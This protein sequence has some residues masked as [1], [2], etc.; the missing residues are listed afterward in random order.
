VARTVRDT[1]LQTRAARLRLKVRGKP[2]WRALERGLHLGYRRTRTGGGSWSARRFVGQGYSEKR[3]G[4]ADDLQDADGAAVLSFGDAQEK[5][6]RWW[7]SEK[8]EELGLAPVTGPYTVVDALRDYF[9]ERD[10]RGSKGVKADR[11]ASEARIVP[12]LG[13]IELARL[14]TQRLRSWQVALAKANKLVRTKSTAPGRATKAL[15][16]NDRRLCVPAGPPPI[17]S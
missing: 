14:T 9:E 10:R 3:L 1:D 2:Y 4:L 16:L 17:A 13:S 8:W 6:R 5:A 11:H 7:K 15:D 12:A